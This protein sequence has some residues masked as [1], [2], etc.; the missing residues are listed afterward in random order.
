MNT[1]GVFPLLVGSDTVATIKTY[2]EA[3]AAVLGGDSGWETITPYSGWGTVAGYPL[4]VRKFG[5]MVELR[6]IIAYNSGSFVSVMCNLPAK[7]RPVGSNIWACTSVLHKSKSVATIVV[8]MS[9]DVWCPSANYYTV[10]PQTGD[11]VLLHGTWHSD[12]V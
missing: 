3:L 7:Y 10:A 4:Q 5:K 11:Y 8:T 12:T 9:G 2:T 1:S 6:G